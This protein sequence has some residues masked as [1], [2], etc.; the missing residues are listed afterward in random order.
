M[1]VIYLWT[2]LLLV[3][4]EAIDVLVIAFSNTNPN[5][6]DRCNQNTVGNDDHDVGLDNA[7]DQ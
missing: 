7:K 4:C 2:L 3:M 6:D 1:P 5:D